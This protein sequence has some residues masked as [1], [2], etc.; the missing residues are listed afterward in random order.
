MEKYI[1][2]GAGGAA[3]AMLRY[4]LSNIQVNLP[5]PVMTFITNLLG[6]VFIGMAVGI[7][8]HTEAPDSLILFLK[9][10]VCGGFTTFSTFSLETLNLL[11]HKKYLAGTSYMVLSVALCVAGVYAGRRIIQ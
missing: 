1:L 9:T 7:S 3:G 2:V 11:E 8:I 5:F 10:G 4:M 6:A